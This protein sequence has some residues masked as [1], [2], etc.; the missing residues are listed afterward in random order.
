[1]DENSF[2]LMSK[3]EKIKTISSGVNAT[4]ALFDKSKVETTL[5]DSIKFLDPASNLH[6]WFDQSLN[7]AEP[8]NCVSEIEIFDIDE[9]V[10]STH[11]FEITILTKDDLRLCNE[12][13]LRLTRKNEESRYLSLI[14]ILI[15]HCLVERYERYKRHSAVNT[16]MGI[17]FKKTVDNFLKY[18]PTVINMFDVPFSNIASNKIEDIVEASNIYDKFHLSI[19][20][21]KIQRAFRRYLSKLILAASKIQKVWRHVISDPSCRPCKNMLMWEFEKLRQ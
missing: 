14:S 15:Y 13:M 1:M 20:A 7:V 3:F 9:G 2:L 16:C 17:D 12:W 6:I 10:V 11:Y 19:R 4:M 21:L 18:A 8:P 5:I